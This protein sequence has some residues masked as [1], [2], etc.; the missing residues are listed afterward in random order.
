MKVQL[1]EKYDGITREANEKL[2]HCLCDKLTKTIY[3]K[4]PGCQGEIVEQGVQEFKEK[5]VE[6]QINVLLS[7]ITLMKAGRAG[8][9]DLTEIGGKKIWRNSLYERK[10]CIISV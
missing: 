2:Y 10:S 3:S 1:D 8:S 9:V 5:T 6:A 7:I 4:M